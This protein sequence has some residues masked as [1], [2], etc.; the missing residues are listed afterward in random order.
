MCI[1]NADIITN[2]SDI[3]SDNIMPSSSHRV[4]SRL[5]SATN[6]ATA[7]APGPRIV[8]TGSRSLS[9]ASVSSDG[10]TESSHVVEQ[11][12]IIALTQDVRSFK[13]ALNKLRRTYQPDQLDS[14]GTLKIVGHEKLGEVLRILRHM[15]EKYPA[16]QSNDLVAAAG[17]LI[18]KVKEF[19]Y[20]LDHPNLDDPKQ[21]FESLD[22]LALA[23]SSRV[24][25]YLMGD[26]DSNVSVST[27]SD[28]TKSYENLLA[29]HEL[30]T[31]GP[32]AAAAGPTAGLS[33][34]LPPHVE[35][36]VIS[37][38]KID[39]LLMHHDCG[40]DLALQRAKIWSKYAKDVIN[41]V[42]KRVG[43]QLELAKNLTKLVQTSRPQLQ[44]ESYLPF[45][46]IYC[47]A[48][49]NDLELCASIQTSCGLLQGY[50]VTFVTFIN[51]K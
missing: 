4:L 2:I 48:L 29:S 21:F 39:S 34:Y 18:R 17:L 23:F 30:D 37:P 9:L 41:Y 27:C 38:D 31:A 44:E 16:L 47:T 7:G 49:D 26:L 51:N 25:E 6:M 5:A 20:N 28:K 14:L 12:D 3:S 24:S 42:E 33:H 36:E 1:T 35:D 8:N 19:D 10:S 45:Q 50:K 22:G 40:V 13:E 32:A 11:E 46:S 43:M 15:L